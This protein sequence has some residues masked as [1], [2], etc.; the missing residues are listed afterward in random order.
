MALTNPRTYSEKSHH[1]GISRQ[2]Y[3]VFLRKRPSYIFYDK[4]EPRQGN[5]G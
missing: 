5:E 4:N 1:L 2:N 3:E